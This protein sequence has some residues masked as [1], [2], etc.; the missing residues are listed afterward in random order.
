[1]ELLYVKNEVVSASIAKVLLVGYAIVIKK[2]I[3]VVNII[4][5]RKTPVIFITENRP[6]LYL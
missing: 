1:L 4:L 2:N 5:E 6:C 3:I